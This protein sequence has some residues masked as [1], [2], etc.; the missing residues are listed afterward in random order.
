LEK[1]T[2]L[3]L[4]KYGNF[5]SN[6][7]VCNNTP[8]VTTNVIKKSVEIGEISS[9][10]KK[11]KKKDKKPKHFISLGSECNQSPILNSFDLWLSQN[12]MNS[13]GKLLDCN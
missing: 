1:D 8:T 6:I 2:L 13:L 10:P 3:H 9:L 11:T 4:Q 12:N 5:P 7:D